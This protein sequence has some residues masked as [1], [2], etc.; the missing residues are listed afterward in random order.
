VTIESRFHQRRCSRARLAAVATG[1]LTL[2]ASVGA[3]TARSESAT[4]DLPRRRPGLWRISTISPEI[5]MQTHEVCIEAGDSIIGALGDDCS[6]PD[7]QSSPDEVI[8]TFSCGRGGARRVTSLLF[9]GDFTSWYRAQS[10]VTVSDGANS[11]RRSGFTIDA[12]HL[13]PECP[14][15]GRE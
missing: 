9:T 13:S 1:I 12:K 6:A 3:E 7:V 8:V 10:R 15:P 2:A 14:K 11:T 4:P 5:G